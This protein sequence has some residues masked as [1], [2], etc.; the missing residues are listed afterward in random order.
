MDQNLRM[1]ARAKA[2]PGR[3]ERKR[4]VSRG[5]AQG[6]VSEANASEAKEEMDAF[7]EDNAG[8]R[9]IVMRLRRT[10]AGKRREGS[11]Q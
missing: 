11:L 4:K 1:P 3:L 5:P 9:R 7:G 10:R 8:S 6:I 2:F